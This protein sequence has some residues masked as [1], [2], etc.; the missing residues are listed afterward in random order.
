MNKVKLVLIAAAALAGGGF[1][2]SSVSART[3][4]DQ[5][6]RCWNEHRN[7]LAVVAPF[8][9]EDQRYGSREYIGRREGSNHRGYRRFHDH[10]ERGYDEP[11]Y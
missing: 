1:T 3:V 11:N 5:G 4:C 9:G 8:L 6:G 2:S 10:G 7:A